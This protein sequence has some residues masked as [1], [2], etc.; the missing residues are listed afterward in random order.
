MIPHTPSGRHLLGLTLA[1]LTT[2]QW[3][4]QG[5]LLKILMGS[6]DVYTIAWTRFLVS[7]IILCPFVLRR[8]TTHSPNHHHRCHHAC[9]RVPCARALWGWG[10]PCRMVLSFMGAR[11]RAC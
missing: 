9:L 1:S 8:R 4:I 2:L 6:L 10:L 7:V 11:A 3:G 5:V